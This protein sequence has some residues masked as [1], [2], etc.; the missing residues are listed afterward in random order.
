MHSAEYLHPADHPDEGPNNARF[1]DAIEQIGVPYTA[2][3]YVLNSIYVRLDGEACDHYTAGLCTA[4]EASQ[5]AAR[6][7]NEEIDETLKEQPEL[8][9]PYEAM[10]ARQKEI[11]ARRQ[12]GEK[13]PLAWIANPFYRQYYQFMKW[14]E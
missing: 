5:Q 13:V 14:A 6:N 4:E 3:P 10:V 12:R 7:I 2:C 11:D 1:A 8:R 9:A